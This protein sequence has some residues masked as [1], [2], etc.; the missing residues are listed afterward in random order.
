MSDKLNK[1]S[2]LAGKFFAKTVN[3]L[4]TV[5]KEVEVKVEVPQTVPQ[6]ILNPEEKI[7]KVLEILY[8][9]EVG[10][11]IDNLINRYLYESDEIVYSQGDLYQCSPSSSS[12]DVSKEIIEDLGIKEIN[13]NL[14][15]AYK[16]K[17]LKILLTNHSSG[18]FPDGDCYDNFGLIV[19]YNGVC[20][21]KDGVSRHFDT[22]GS[23]YRTGNFSSTSLELFKNGSW[24]DDLGYLIRNFD[25]YE[26][27]RDLID[28]V[29][30]RKKLAEKLDLNPLD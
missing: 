28:E 8:S 14:N 17:I 11:N 13:K 20:V 10:K 27:K 22:Y 2:F 15:F 9:K 21:L 6:A 7:R 12:T 3:E 18:S 4:K 16:G 23:T 25:D 24:I 29:E 5:E 26:K 30:K 19:I 1:F